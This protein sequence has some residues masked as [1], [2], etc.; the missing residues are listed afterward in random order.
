MRVLIGLGLAGL[1]M[2]QPATVHVTVR[3]L[4]LRGAKGG[5]L[6]VGLHRAPGTG[7]PGPSEFTNQTVQP[8]GDESILTFEAV[9]GTFAVAVHHDANVNGRMDS[10]FFGMPKEG[11][12]V[13]NDVRP[14]F[15]APRFSEAAVQVRRDTTIVVHMAY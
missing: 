15:R 9:P 5:V 14:K 2:F 13:S 3:L 8:A 12:G 7:F 10:N 1:T 4:D 11:Y 6:R